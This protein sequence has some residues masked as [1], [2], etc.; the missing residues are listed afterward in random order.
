[1]TLRA[2]IF[3]LDGTLVNSNFE[4]VEAWE[5]AFKKFKHDVEAE[6]IKTQIGK[7]GDKLVPSILGSDIDE[8]EQ[9]RLEDAHGE[10][11]RGILEEKKLSLFPG[12][13]NV[14][15]ELRSLGLKLALATSSDKSDIKRLEKNL[16]VTFIRLFDVVVTS[17]HADESK[18]APDIVKIAVEKLEVLPSD[19][20][21]VGD[22]PYD[23]QAAAGAGVS[24]IGLTCGG[25]NDS[26]KLIS[27]GA[28]NVFIDPMDM[29][30]N[31]DR[32]VE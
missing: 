15:Q 25:L 22:T 9:E 3:D 19:C 32:I 2:I 27:S 17:D 28:R 31:I 24:C 12:V 5:K 14:L 8:K 20:V 1:M 16:G 26:A 7:G 4:H 21:M 18:P 13:E 11:F 10:E 30:G 23:C 6:R 29:L